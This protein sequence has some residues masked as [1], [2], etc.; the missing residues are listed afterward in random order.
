ML[1]RFGTSGFKGISAKE[2]PSTGVGL[3]AEP[4]FL[5][6]SRN[7][8][9]NGAFITPNQLNALLFDYLAESRNLG[10]GVA[11][12]GASHPV[13][14]VAACGDLPVVGTLV[15]FKHIGELI[16]ED[17]SIFD[18][19]ESARLPIKSYC[20]TEDGIVAS[21]FAAKASATRSTRLTAAS[22]GTDR[23]FEYARNRN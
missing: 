7:S 11:R 3:A 5:P 10:G 14:R 18:S 19:E 23:S 16:N 15:G 8:S 13:A 22:I 2:I 17:K 12:S 9:T 1:I 4:G 20:P 6:E 21:L